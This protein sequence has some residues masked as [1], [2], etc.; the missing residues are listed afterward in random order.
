MNEVAFAGPTGSNML[1]PLR[2]GVTGH[3]VLADLELVRAGIDQSLS[4]IEE[5]HPGRP[6]VV[7]SSHAEGTDR[8]VTEIVLKRPGS[9][10]EAV[11]PEGNCEEAYA[12]ANDRLLEKIDVLVAVWD[13]REAQ[14]RG[15]TAEVV[16]R[17]RACH[18][19]LA[20]VHAGNRKPGTV[21]S[22]TLGPEQGRVTFEN[23]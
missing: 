1:K 16:A 14:G 5:C 18:L 7:V 2:I 4:R 3:R 12:A 8:L 9:R 6:L 11:L 17:A 13:G 21:E 19:P 20:W 15:G 23:L 10:L 22:T